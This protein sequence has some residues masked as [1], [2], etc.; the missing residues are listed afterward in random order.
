MESYFIFAFMGVVLL[1]AVAISIAI[2]WDK[3]PT[4]ARY[5]YDANAIQA[6]ILADETLSDEERAYL[7]EVAVLELPRR[8]LVC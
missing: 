4:P 5:R 8:H 1:I 2:K 7:E 3:R 6:E